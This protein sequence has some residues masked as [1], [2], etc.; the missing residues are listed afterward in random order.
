VASRFDSLVKQAES[1]P[2]VDGLAHLA[3][4]ILDEVD[5][6]ENVFTGK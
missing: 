3:T 2:G 4:P 6:L 1:A 5:H